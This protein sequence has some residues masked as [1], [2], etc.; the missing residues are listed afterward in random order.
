MNTLANRQ[1][2]QQQDEKRQT[3]SGTASGFSA[4]GPGLRWT[5]P[6][7]TRGRDRVLTHD[8]G[9]H[10]PGP[11]GVQLVEG[12]L[13]V[14]HQGLGGVGRSCSLKGHR[15]E[16]RENR[17]IHDR[18]DVEGLGYLGLLQQRGEAFQDRV[19]D[20]VVRGHPNAEP[21]VRGASHDL[22]SI[23]TLRI[24]SMNLK[25]K[26]CFLESLCTM[27]ESSSQKLDGFHGIGQRRNGEVLP[28]LR[29]LLGVRRDERASRV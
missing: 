12:D 24:A 11:L 6:D 5:R 20:R 26:S 15:A 7:P 17:I 10:P 25:A 16:R 14:L 9:S 4:P 3:E 21:G 2:R 28:S 1:C 22:I 29:V 18:G 27:N 13:H 23:E 8:D 19:G